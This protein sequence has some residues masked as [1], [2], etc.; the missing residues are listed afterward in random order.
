MVY[1]GCI[2][3]TGFISVSIMINWQVFVTKEKGRIS[4]IGE[5]LAAYQEL[6]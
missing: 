3:Y 6:P 5:Q 4:W 1:K 2:L